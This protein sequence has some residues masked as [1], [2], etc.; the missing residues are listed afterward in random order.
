[1]IRWVAGVLALLA[2][3]GVAYYYF[4]DDPLR[5]E[6]DRRWP[7]LTA[8]LQRQATIDSAASALKGSPRRTWRRGPTSRRSRRLSR[9]ARPNS[10]LA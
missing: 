9:G 2:V 3:G 8:N 1:M 6:L 4:H 7:G 5:A 10:P